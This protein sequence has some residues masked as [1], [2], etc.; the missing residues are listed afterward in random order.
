MAEE[1]SPYP[2][3]QL[4]VP[5]RDRVIKSKNSGKTAEKPSTS[6]GGRQQKNWLKDER[7]EL[8]LKEIEL[9][10]KG[11]S[12]R[13]VAQEYGIPKSTLH[14]HATGKVRKG[15]HQGP[16]RYLTD[17]EEDALCNFVVGCADVGY[18]RTVKQVVITL[19]T[20]FKFSKRF[21]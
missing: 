7:L 18:P 6:I 17:M 3:R 21:Y 19:I 11:K 5:L 15:A 2:Q 10:G 1:Y 13:Q 4:D 12:V 14:D 8:A 9:S 20:Y 16:E